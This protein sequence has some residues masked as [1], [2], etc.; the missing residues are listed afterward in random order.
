MSKS[1]QTYLRFRVRIA[2]GYLLSHGGKVAREY[3]TVH[4]G[5]VLADKLMTQMVKRYANAPTELNPYRFLTLKSRIKERIRL[6][7]GES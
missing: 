3:L 4:Y 1:E 2:C 7:R 5:P 6:L